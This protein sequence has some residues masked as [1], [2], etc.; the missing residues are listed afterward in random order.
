MNMSRAEFGRVQVMLLRSFIE[1]IHEMRD[2]E[3]LP[4]R[5][6]PKQMELFR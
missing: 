2:F 3:V 5:V 4:I 6:A 1:C